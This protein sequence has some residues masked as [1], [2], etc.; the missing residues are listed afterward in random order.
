MVLRFWN[1]SRARNAP[2][3]TRTAAG[4][5]GFGAIGSA[6]RRTTRGA[7]ARGAATARSICRPLV[8]PL[9]YV[10]CAARWRRTLLNSWSAPHPALA[11]R[12]GSSVLHLRRPA[13]ARRGVMLLQYRPPVACR[14]VELPA[15]LIDAGES[16]LEAARRELKEETGYVGG[17]HLSTTPVLHT[18]PW[19]STETTVCVTLEVDL[20]DPQNFRR[21][22][23]SRDPSPRCLSCRHRRWGQNRGLGAG[24]S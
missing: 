6:Q 17:K 15:G 2:K 5:A 1:I 7:H 22:R 3:R 16:P 10:F 13:A 20:D 8:A 19:L 23:R 12:M 4:A 11:P 18:A 21:S 14:A 24:T 9:C